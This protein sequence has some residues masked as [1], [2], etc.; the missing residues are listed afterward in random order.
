MRSGNW[1]DIVD[2]RSDTVTHPTPEMRES[3]A[4]AEVGDDVYGEDP[5]IN[6]LEMM[7]AERLGKE[8]ALFVASGTM[9][10]LAAILAHCSRGDEIILGNHSHTFLFEAGGAAALGGIHSWTVA[11]QEDGT[12]RLEDIENAVRA[13]DPHYPISRLICLENTHNRCGGTPLSVAYTREVAKFAK[14]KDLLLHID[15]AR[16]FN[17]AIAQSVEAKELAEP[18]DSVM[19]CLSKGLCAPVGSILCGTAGFI[20][21]ARRIRKQ[22]GGGMRQAGILAAA[23]IIALEKMVDRLAE[24][25]R[26]ARVLAQGLCEIPGLKVEK[27]PP[28]TN[29]VYVWVEDDLAYDA[30]DIERALQKR[31]ILIGDVEKQRIR[32]VVHYW[33]D[34]DAISRTMYAFREV[35]EA[36]GIS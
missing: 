1:K 27:N 20:H 6:R 29:M 12:L 8:S 15:G 21:K 22:L 35:M 10:N 19:F 24:D 11:N 4:H 14:R 2:L 25:H 13:D 5:T 3:M 16:I 9:G 36:S 17:A 33:I 7:A 32:L 34:D 26:R 28:P 30:S 18:A 31:G 23:G